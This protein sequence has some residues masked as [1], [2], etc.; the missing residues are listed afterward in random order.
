MRTLLLIGSQICSTGALI[1]YSTPE[2]ALGYDKMWLDHDRR[3]TWAVGG[4]EFLD[5]TGVALKTESS[6]RKVD[7]G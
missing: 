2:Q 6:E 1:E 7:R 4:I 5:N 3:S